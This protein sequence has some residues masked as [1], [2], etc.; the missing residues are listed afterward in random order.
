MPSG[1]IC[2]SLAVSGTALCYHHSAIRTALGKARQTGTPIPFVFPED[3]AALQ[4]NYFLLLQ[5]YTEGRI[6]L[7]TFNSMQRLLRAMAANLGKKPLADDNANAAETPAAAGTSN[8]AT[9]EKEMKKPATSVNVPPAASPREQ[10]G[11]EKLRPRPSKPASPSRALPSTIRALTSFE[12]IAAQHKALGAECFLIAAN[13][14]RLSSSL[15]A[16]R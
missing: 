8:I 13:Q 9:S 5:A 1:A 11:E 3:R 7:R 2:G 4:I 10:S 14:P 12:D 15:I 16:D 6:D